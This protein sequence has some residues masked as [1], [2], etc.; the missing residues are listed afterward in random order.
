LRF[1][2]DALIG[3]APGL[4]DA[5]AGLLG[6]YGLLTAYHLGAPAPVLLRLLLN[7]GIDLL[8]GAVPLLG[9][10]FDVAWKGNLRNVALLDRWLAEPETTRRRSTGLFGLILF[11]LFLMILAA[12][13]AAFRVVGWVVGLGR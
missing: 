12:C 2:W 11:A 8:F 13:Y 7:L 1:G 10:L 3:L 5:V 4:G 9:D 6:A